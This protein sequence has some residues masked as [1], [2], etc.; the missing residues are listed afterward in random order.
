MKG[1]VIGYWVLTGLFALG[2]GMGG[3]VD[4]MAGPDVAE[5]MKHLGY[6]LYFAKMLGYFKVAG[7]AVLLAPG[8]ARAKEWAYAGIF[9]DLVAASVSHYSVGDPVSNIATPILF[10]AVAGGSY[11]LRPSTRVMGQLFSGDQAAQPAAGAAA[12]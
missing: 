8:L 12:T 9:I 3:V 6:P 5:G 2:F 11:A 10:L 7:V 4:V 1:K